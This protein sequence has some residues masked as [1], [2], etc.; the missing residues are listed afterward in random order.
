MP[1]AIYHARAGLA[2]ARLSTDG[3]RQAGLREADVDAASRQ[4]RRRA[5]DVV[6]LPLR[7]LHGATVPGADLA[8]GNR[9]LRRRLRR[10][11]LGGYRLGL[12]LGAPAGGCRSRVDRPPPCSSGAARSWCRTCSRRSRSPAGSWPAWSGACS[13]PLSW[14]TFTPARA[15]RSIFGIT[16]VAGT[17]TAALRSSSRSSTVAAAL[18]QFFPGRRS[19]RGA[20][21]APPARACAAARDLR[22]CSASSRSRSS[23]VLA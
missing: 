2:S 1:I 10:A 21:R 4:P 22:S 8:R 6:L 19:E 9:L 15:L 12:A 18:P 16:C 23:G 14:G 5:A 17:V 3:R 13:G 20:G 11:H 7:R